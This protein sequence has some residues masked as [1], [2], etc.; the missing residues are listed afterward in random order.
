MTTSIPL[1]EDLLT[2]AKAIADYLGWPARKVFYAQRYLPIRT[3]GRM[4]IARKSE[5]DRALSGSKP[6]EVAS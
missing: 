6:L 3:V 5:L 2:G 4:L 1:N